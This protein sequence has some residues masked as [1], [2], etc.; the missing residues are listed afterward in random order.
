ML[1]RWAH[2]LIFLLHISYRKFEGNYAEE[3]HYYCNVGEFAAIFV[4]KFTPVVNV[5]IKLF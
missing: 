1:V 4:Q 2:I 3:C 5:F